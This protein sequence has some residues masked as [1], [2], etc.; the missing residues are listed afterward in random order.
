[1]LYYYLILI[2]AESTPQVI[3]IFNTE[4]AGQG[5]RLS[6]QIFIKINIKVKVEYLMK[7]SDI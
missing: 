7:K 5:R 2:K 3:I 4:Y 1:M 6:L